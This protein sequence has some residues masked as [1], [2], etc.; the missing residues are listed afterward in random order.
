MGPPAHW[1]GRFRV[2][3]KNEMYAV[4]FPGDLESGVRL[5]CAS[6]AVFKRQIAGLE[7]KLALA[8]FNFSQ[9]E[10]CAVWILVRTMNG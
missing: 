6:M 2:Q 10:L 9:N 8:S 4:A 7:R 3:W 5:P 1:L